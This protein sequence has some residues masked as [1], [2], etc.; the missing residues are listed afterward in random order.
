MRYVV[1]L[2]RFSADCL[3]HTRCRSSRDGL[4]MHRARVE[5][6]LAFF[7]SLPPRLLRFRRVSACPRP[8]NKTASRS[9]LINLGLSYAPSKRARRIRPKY[10]QFSGLILRDL[11]AECA[12][13][14]QRDFFAC[15]APSRAIPRPSHESVVRR[16]SSTIDGR[17]GAT[18]RNY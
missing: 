12:M 6:S 17:T 8:I 13:L 3:W 1:L 18:F 16:R 15:A 10:V 5:H 4:Q 9:T 2:L 11:S 14:I 7:D